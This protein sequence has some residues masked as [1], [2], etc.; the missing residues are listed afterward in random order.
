MAES[1]AVTAFAGPLLCDRIGLWVYL[2]EGKIEE[3]GPD[4]ARAEGDLAALALQA[5][6]NAC[7][8]LAGLFV[9]ASDGAVALI[10]R[11]DGACAGGEE[12]RPGTDGDGSGDG[13]LLRVDFEQGLVLEG[14]NPDEAVREERVFRAGREVD[15]GD[16]LVGCG[17]DA[18]KRGGF[19][20][21]PDGAFACGDAA[22]GVGGD[23]GDGGYGLC[24]GWVDAEEHVISAAR[25]PDGAE[26]VY[27]SGTGAL[28]VGGQSYGVCGGQ[29]L[30]DV[31]ETR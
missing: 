13:V 16:D 24:G 25:D 11:P 3:R 4:E 30:H 2:R 23:D 31:V 18:D 6:W 22:F 27:E 10:Q 17:V 5:A 9:D 20:D 28:Y 29:E 7:Q 15:G 12:A 14:G 19:G 26:S 21:D 8:D 1:D